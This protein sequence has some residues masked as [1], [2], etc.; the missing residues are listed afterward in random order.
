MTSPGPTQGS[1]ILAGSLG[2]RERELLIEKLFRGANGSRTAAPQR[3]LEGVPNAA[4]LAVLQRQG[5]AAR[6]LLALRAP[7]S[8]GQFSRIG[9]AG[10]V[11]TGVASNAGA[12][13]GVSR[14]TALAKAPSPQS[15]AGRAVSPSGSSGAGMA[16]AEVPCPEGISTVDGE[17]SGV[18]FSPVAGDQGTFVIQ[19]CGFGGAPGEVYLSGVQY[20][21]GNAREVM[22]LG[23]PTQ[24]DRVSFQIPPNGWSDR[25]ITA[26][27]DPNAGGLLDTPDVT[28]V[29]KTAQGRTYQASGFTFYAAEVFHT[30]TFLPTAPSSA[31]VQLE[32]GLEP[33]NVFVAP[34]VES[35]WNSP[36][37]RRTILVSRL[38]LSGPLFVVAGP[39]TYT[40]HFAV[41]SRIHK[42]EDG[43]QLFLPNGP[44]NP[45]PPG[46]GEEPVQV[47]YPDYASLDAFCKG[48]GAQYTVMVSALSPV[49]YTSGTSFEVRSAPAYCIPK[50]DDIQPIDWSKVRATVAVYSLQIQLIGP[51]GVN[52]W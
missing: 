48:Y 18:W 39:D 15:A 37:G 25:R 29:V 20:A 7:T 49:V 44:G 12:P 30:L 38:N 47:F 31:S 3:S 13:T 26:V 8:Q 6:A 27:I 23:V 42:P 4:V 14:P 19:G 35:P 10:S 40:F 1:P 17:K 45:P 51:R 5:A 11:H 50:Q 34:D 28:L 32:P 46:S 36:Q 21:V 22:H 2:K 43:F 24:P 33:N 52:P 9:G 16:V 41:N